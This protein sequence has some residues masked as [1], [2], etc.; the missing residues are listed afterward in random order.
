MKIS[1]KRASC[2][3][4]RIADLFCLAPVFLDRRK[5]YPPKECPLICLLKTE[6]SICKVLLE[7]KKRISSRNVVSNN[8]QVSLCRRRPTDREA[9][10][11]PHCA[12]FPVPI[13][14]CKHPCARR[15]A[16][17]LEPCIEQP[18]DTDGH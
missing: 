7:H 16:H 13:P 15:P 3:F 18:K 14:V 2:V 8:R 9:F 12:E 11:I 5:S 17:C 4:M 10:H 1:L 6:L